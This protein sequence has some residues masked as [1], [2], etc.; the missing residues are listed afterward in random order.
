MKKMKFNVEGM[1]CTSCEML[2]SDSLTE[3]DGVSNVE[4]S[5]KKGFVKV[6]FDDSKIREDD[7][8]KVIEKEGYKVLRVVK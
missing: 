4:V 7:I 2:I 1:H 5:H 8:I 6:A 3:I